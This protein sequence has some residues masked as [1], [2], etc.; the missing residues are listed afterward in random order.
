MR[1]HGLRAA[2]ALAAAVLAGGAVAADERY[3]RK[4]AEAAAEIAAARMGPLRG[5]FAPG[6]RP[7]LF[8][9]PLEEPA[10]HPARA[11]PPPPAPGEWRDGLAIAV[12]RKP[13]ASP[14]L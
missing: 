4:L 2:V 7:A 6:E 5:G 10:R 13:G 9:P 3:D 14:E 8:V 11:A 12:E 1:V